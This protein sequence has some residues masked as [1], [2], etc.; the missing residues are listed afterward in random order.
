MVT[1]TEEILNGKLYFLCSGKSMTS[2]L[3]QW[4]N[5]FRKVFLPAVFCAECTTSVSA[6]LRFRR[7]RAR[8]KNF[9]REENNAS[10]YNNVIY[11]YELVSFIL[12]TYHIQHEI[13]AS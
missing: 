13:L 3:L 8:W 12:T 5:V 10:E 4:C 1:L 9:C 11:Y 6:N 7:W 2:A